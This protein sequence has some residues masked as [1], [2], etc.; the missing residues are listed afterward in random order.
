MAV[1]VGE[2]DSVGRVAG[3]AS[4][5]CSVVVVGAGPYGLAAATHLHR[6]GLDVRV[7]GEPMGSW[8]RHMP[9]G[10]LLRSLWGASHIADPDH[11][12][13]LDAYEVDRRLPHEKRIPLERFVDYGRWYQ[14]RAVPS[15]DRRRVEL[16]EQNANGFHVLLEDGEELHSGRV[17]VAAGIVPFAWRPPDLAALPRDLVSHSSEHSDLAGFGGQR[18]LVVGGGQSAFESA[19][20]LHEGGAEVEVLVRRAVF[21]HTEVGHVDTDELRR[22]LL[23]YAYWRTAVGG[24]RSSW[25]AAYPSLCRLIPRETRARFSYRLTRAACAYWLRPRLAAVK[26][27]E[28]RSVD[29]ASDR[30]GRV[31]LRL[32]DGSTREVDHVLL[33]TGYRIDVSRYAFLPPELLRRIRTWNGSPL[34]T[35]GFESSV[36][37]LH[38][39]GETAAASFGPVLRFVCGTWAAARGVTRGIVGRSAPRAGFTW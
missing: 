39:L 14:E 33:G 15:L 25:I 13:G 6:E 9:A 29:S 8:A 31:V 30:G 27:T 16:V 18:V 3:T 1:G 37:G 19:A 20:L 35:G 21:W 4:P 2:R 34:L 26:V 7:F 32:S 38:F 23:L 11:A 10:M 17:V 28:G 12:L 22:R 24:P 36:P 5:S